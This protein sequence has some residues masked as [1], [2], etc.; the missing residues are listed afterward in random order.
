M[1]LKETA[2]ELRQGRATL[3]D[4]ARKILE[5]SEAEKRLTVNK[6]NRHEHICGNGK[7]NPGEAFRLGRADLADR[8]DDRHRR[9]ARR[10]RVG[11]Q[12]DPLPTRTPATS[13][14]GTI[15]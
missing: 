4:E 8:A 11:R 14:G 13:A 2:A 9:Q 7:D 10:G 6:H 12:I 1:A 5:K 3:I 15:R